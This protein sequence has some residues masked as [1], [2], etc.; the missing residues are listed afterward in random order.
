MDSGIETRMIVI[1][2]SSE[3]QTEQLARFINSLGYGVTVKETCYGANVEGKKEDV[4]KVL[5]EVRK[6]D[7]NRVFSKIRAFPIGDER[8]CRAHHGS[9]PG[10]PQLEKEWKDLS[11]IDK[12]LCACEHG[13]IYDEKKKPEKLSVNRLIEIVK[14]ECE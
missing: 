3:L 4:R 6:L 5:D 2:P 7:P 10:F 13:E 12:G 14:E 8:R 11:L 1:A 9:R